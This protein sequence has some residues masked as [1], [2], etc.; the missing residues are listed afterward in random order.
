[1]A[2]QNQL[3]K[4]IFQ[5]LP[6]DFLIH[7]SQL[8]DTVNSLGGYSGAIV[9]HDHIDL[10][11]KQ[12]KNLGSPTDPSDAIAHIF[13]EKNY[14]A[15]AV[16]PRLESTGSN[17]LKT[18]RRV[19]DP[20]QREGVSSF[21][22]DLMS[23]P[24]S[25]N[26]IIPLTSSGGGGVVVT[27]PASPFTFADNSSIILESRTDTLPLPPAFTIVSISCVANLVTVQTSTPTGLAVGD[28]FTVTGVSPASFN[29]SFTVTS[30]IN[31]TTFTYQLDIGTVSGSGGHIELN[32]VWYYMI[33]KRQ[34]YVALFG[35]TSGD[36]AQNR[37]GV[38]HDSYQIVAVVVVTNS[39]HNVASSG[40]G[41]SALIGPPTAGAFF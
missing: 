27:I 21:L 24:P 3:S 41:G 10:N 16:Q 40:G 33:H 28:S 18:M 39:G 29:G 4:P 38:C 25:A 17:P 23:T 5:G 35:P 19:S 34:S 13:A 26:N 6:A 30:V 11:G 15:E 32:N 20:N 14:S 8:I 7:Y 36:T 1:M 2:D 12:V 31:P 22:N 9:L 37:L